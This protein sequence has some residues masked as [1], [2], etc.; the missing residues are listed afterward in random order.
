[1]TALGCSSCLDIHLGDYNLFLLQDY[2][3]GHH[4]AGKVAAGGNITLDSFGVGS[5]LAGTNITNT[6]VAGGNL[7]LSSGGVAGDTWYGG[8]YT[9]NWSVR[10]SPGTL[11]RGTPIDFEARF[12]ELRSLSARLATRPI[13]GATEPRWGNLYMTGTDPCLNVFE[14][15][16]SDFKNAQGRN[17]SAPAGSFVVVNIRGTALSFNGGVSFSGGIT[18]QRVLYNFVEATNLDARG[19]GLQGT[20]LAPYAH[21]TLNDGS[22]SGGIYAVSLHGN[23]TGNL[24]PLDDMEAAKPEECNGADDN[25][26][27]QVDEG[28]ECT[29]TGNRG[30][31]AW[32]GATGTQ[33]C[34]AATCGYGEC[35]SSSCCQAD[36]DCGGGFYCEG[37]LCTAQ[38]SNGASCSSANQCASGQCVDGV[39]CNTACAGE[40][41]ACNLAGQEGTCSPAPSTVQCRASTG[42]CDVAEYC[43]GAS[44]SCPANGSQASGV[45]CTSDNNACTL[46]ACD[47]SG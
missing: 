40:C 3:G 39:C 4:V 36:A 16:A 10:I 12:D 9:P 29:G 33:T 47:G 44:A 28:F 8:S 46:D 13:N 15:R 25:C 1:M 23:A 18:P 17:I 41:D 6:L 24:S 30:C 35:T 31:T 11:A 5:A 45:A 14:V 20:V 19:F 38:R 7:T 27:G 37:T 21:V 34:D 2:S 32:C 42:E 22:W 43:T 26:D